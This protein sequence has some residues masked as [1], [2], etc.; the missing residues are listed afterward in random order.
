[1]AEVPE[2]FQPVPTPQ[3]QVFWDGCR[4]GR[5]L[6]QQCGSCGHF[7]FYPRGFC[8][9]CMRRDPRWVPAS[10]RGTIATYTIVRTPV[11]P[12]YAAETPY[13]IALIRLEEGPVMM[14]QVTGCDPGDVRSGM[15]V[16]VVFRA[17]TERITMPEFRL[18]P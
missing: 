6:I 15:P 14:S 11:S 13:V 12:A 3:T 4:E 5:L 2:K 9:R 17:R 18:R 10:G 7:Q 16:E 1:V 8:T